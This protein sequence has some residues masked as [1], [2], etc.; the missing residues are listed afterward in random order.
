[1]ASSPDRLL[2]E[3]DYLVCRTQCSGFDRD[4]P[5]GVRDGQNS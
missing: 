1:M 4:G 2:A 5:L 3:I